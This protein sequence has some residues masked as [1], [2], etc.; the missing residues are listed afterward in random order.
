MGSHSYVMPK[1]RKFLERYHAWSKDMAATYRALLPEKDYEYLFDPYWVSAYP[2]R[3]DLSAESSQ[4]VTVT[5][6]NFRDTPQ[7]HRV[8]LV[9]PDGVTASPSILEGEVPA[10]SRRKYQVKLTAKNST[11]ARG[12]QIVPF[13]ITLDDKHYGQLFDFLIRLPE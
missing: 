13:D 6:R 3:V 2:Y 1:P 7:R 11:E 12:L 4:E 10:E 9:L 5:I 8:K